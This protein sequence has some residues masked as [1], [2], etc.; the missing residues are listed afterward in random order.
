MEPLYRGR[1]RMPRF[2]IGER[3]YRW[4]RKLGVTG[5]ASLAA[6]FLIATAMV[7]LEVGASNRDEAA[8]RKFLENAGEDPVTFLATRSR[9]HRLLF[10]SDVGGSTAPKRLVA[11]AVEEI[12]ESSGLDALVLQVPSNLQP[13]IDRYLNSRPEDASLLVGRPE[14]TRER[15]GGSSD[16]LD[17]YRT[18][19]RVNQELGPGRSIR[20]VAADLPDAPTG[21]ALSPREAARLHDRRSTH[22]D[23]IMR[24]EILQPFPRARVLAFLDG[25]QVLKGEGATFEIGGS[26]PIQ[27]QWAASRLASDYPTETYSTLVEVPASRQELQQIAAYR[28][29][30][31]SEAVEGVNGAAAVPIDDHFA[32]LANPLIESSGAGTEM[33]ILPRGYRLGEVADGFILPA[34]R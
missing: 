25:Y 2:D 15:T 16:Y 31:F 8:L 27:V 14:L 21:A 33:A 28:G 34:R 32:F 9:A 20:I 22:I 5:I 7:V 4:R 19:W 29:T 12:A 17:I 26:A 30:L 6:L 24:A 10:L 13:V 1:S 18:V 23:S 3:L 11:D